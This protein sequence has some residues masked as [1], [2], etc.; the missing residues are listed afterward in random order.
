MSVAR[1]RATPNHIDH[2][3][4]WQHEGPTDAANAGPMCPR[5]D[6]HKNHGYTIWRDTHGRWPPTDP[7]APRSTPPDRSA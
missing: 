1:L 7:T 3:L 6:R 4:D 5:H 2:T